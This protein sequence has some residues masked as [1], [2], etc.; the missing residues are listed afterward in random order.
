MKQLQGFINN[1]HIDKKPV[2]KEAKL[3][4]KHL[5]SYKIHIVHE[6]LQQSKL[7]SNGLVS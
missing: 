2:K 6:S 3:A 4:G 1:L 5:T 7:G